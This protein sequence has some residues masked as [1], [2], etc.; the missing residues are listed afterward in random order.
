MSTGTGED[1]GHGAGKPEIESARGVA[2]GRR[3]EH[4]SDWR[5]GLGEEKSSKQRL[6]AHRTLHSAVYSAL[7]IAY[8]EAEEAEPSQSIGQCT[9]QCPVHTALFGEPRL[10]EFWNV[11][12]I[13]A[14]IQIPTY[15]HTKEHLLGQ[16]LAPSHILSYFSKCFAIGYVVFRKISKWWEFAF[17]SYTRGFMNEM[18]CECSP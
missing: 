7:W 18:R 13:F 15:K 17:E 16:V 11:S 6:W 3:N 10:R 8:V 14:S 5:A 1:T 4:L 9:V 2:G 12:E